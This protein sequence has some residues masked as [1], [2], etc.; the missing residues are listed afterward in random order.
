MRG[1]M[2]CVID[3]SKGLIPFQDSFRRFKRRLVPYQPDFSRGAF[4]IDEGLIQ[5]QWL[6]ETP[7]CSL[8]VAPIP[9]TL[10]T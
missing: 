6:Q 5:V 7:R 9:C 4:A 8:F 2:K 3:N 1:Q 10:P